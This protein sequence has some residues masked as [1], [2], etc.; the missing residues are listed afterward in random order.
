MTS[1]ECH[2][3]TTCGRNEDYIEE[4]NGRGKYL[5]IDDT[6]DTDEVSSQNLRTQVA[7]LT[8]TCFDKQ[9]YFRICKQSSNSKTYDTFVTPFRAIRYVID[10]HSHK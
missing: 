7:E 4:P 6:M 1:P 2:A 8:Q 5:R 3:T 10:C 9:N